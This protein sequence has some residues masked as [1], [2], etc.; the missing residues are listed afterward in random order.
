[1]SSDNTEEFQYRKSEKLFAGPLIS[2]YMAGDEHGSLFIST[3]AVVTKFRE[4]FSELQSDS[5]AQVFID[6]IGGGLLL[7]IGYSYVLHDRVAFDLSVNYSNSWLKANVTEQLYS[8]KKENFNVGELSFSFGF[9]VI[10]D[11]FFF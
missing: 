6:G 3:A 5:S 10:L 1:M 9:S 4:E 7:R 8:K 11:D 2:W